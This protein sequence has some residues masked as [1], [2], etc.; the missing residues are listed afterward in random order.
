MEICRLTIISNSPT[1][2]SRRRNENITFLGER[3]LLPIFIVN[4]TWNKGVC[5]LSE[6]PNLIEGNVT[7]GCR[8]FLENPLAHRDFSDF[9]QLL[10]HP[11]FAFL[12]EDGVEVAVEQGAGVLEVGFGVGYGGGDPRERGVEEGHN[13]LLFGERGKR[14]WNFFKFAPGKL[15]EGSTRAQSIELINIG[16]EIVKQIFIIN[17]FSG[18]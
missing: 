14:D 11:P 17:L 9:S 10:L 4:V 1:D 3:E 8:L 13:P 2:C 6:C 16:M 12:G 5:F 15:F 7:C 18:N